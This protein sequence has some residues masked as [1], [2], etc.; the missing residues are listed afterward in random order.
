[1]AHI[2]IDGYNLIGIAH[3]DLEKARQ[4]LIQKLHGYTK[5]KGHDITLVFDGWKN[6]QLRETITKLGGLTIIYSKL[7]E[8]A[9]TVIKKILSS[10]TKQWVVVSSD[11]EISDFAEGKDFA[12]VTADEFEGKLYSTDKQN[13]YEKTSYDKD[14]GLMPDRQKGNPRK[15]SKRE[16]KKL[17][18]LRN[19]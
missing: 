7:G 14:M 16:M 12:A 17:R 8:K 11:R 10:A 3:K 13:N 2:L 15:L 9:D 5:T 6:G 1:M 4:E 18:A 19:L